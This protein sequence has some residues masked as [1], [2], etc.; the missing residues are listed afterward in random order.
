MGGLGILARGF[1]RGGVGR[2]PV[3]SA[4]PKPMLEIGP[5]GSG[6]AG[7]LIPGIDGIWTS[8]V[9]FLGISTPN[10]FW[11]DLMLAI[12]SV[13]VRIDD[14][15]SWTGGLNPP[16]CVGKPAGENAGRG[17]VGWGFGEEGG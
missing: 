16:A 4:L 7:F 12:S 15:Y 6:A 1:G 14:L 3:F 8:G 17:G 13:I 9:T 10:G 11:P 5:I 2:G